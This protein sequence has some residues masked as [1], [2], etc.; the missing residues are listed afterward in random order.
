MPASFAFP[1]QDR[2]DAEKGIWLPWQPSEAMRQGRGFTVAL[3]VGRL[4]PGATERQANAELSTIAAN[5]K[6][7]SPSDARDLQFALLPYQEMVTGAIRPVFLALTAALGLVLL[8]ACANVA[9]L[10]LS[11][12]LARD[13]ELAIRTALGAPKWRLLRE[14]VAE[15]AV[16]SILGALVGLAIAFAILQA[17]HAL[18]PDMIPRAGEIHLRLTILLAL[19]LLAALV[20]VLSSIT[21]ALFALGAE[22][23]SVLRGA[24]RG[25]SARAARSR[26]AAFIVV[27]EV[28]LAAVL[29]VACSLLFRTL[30]NL[31]HK[32]LGFQVENLVTFRATPPSSAGYLSGATEPKPGEQSVA[33]HVYSPILDELRKLPGVDQ[34]A[35]TSSIPFDGV[36]MHTSFSLNGHENR[37]QEEKNTYHAMIRVMSGD[38]MQALHTPMV[39]GR[40]I[41][42]DDTGTQQF[43]AVVNQAFARRFLKGD[44][45][46]QK[47]ELGGKEIGMEKPYTILGITADAVQKSTASPAEPELMLP[48]LQIPERSLFYPI[49]ISSA[50]NYLL[51]THGQADLA[52]AVHSVFKKV[53]PGFAI[54]NLQTMRKTVDSANFNHRLGFYLIGSFAGVAILMVMV[55]LY[56][57][58]A[59]FVNQ[60]R[61]EIG[62][63][64]ALGASGESI[65][66]LILRQGSVLIGTGLIIG[67]AGSLAASKLIASFLYDVQPM[68]IESHAGAAAALL[69]VGL[70]AALVPARRASVIEPMEALRAE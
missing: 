9:N 64:M 52:T 49:L 12:C 66:A 29:L 5:I 28:A 42:N 67:L 32:W 61:Q 39:R 4:R 38:Y 17:V 27:G 69:V 31:E 23:Q 15:G 45:I 53:A 48:Y 65:L 57:I 20:T 1:D 56:G 55:G 58:L 41:S 19:A 2:S 16:L 7:Q 33:T 63:R 14:L 60:R 22:P 37:T 70:L 40:A 25:M 21:P 6:R 36:D 13:Q 11:R 24:G 34:A 51:R 30:Y 8:I 43:V 47:I 35:L 54:D 46:G 62:V 18:P 10:Q 68:D 3:L 26:M 44:P 59:Q 50:T